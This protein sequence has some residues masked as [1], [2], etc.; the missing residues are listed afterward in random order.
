MAS[1]YTMVPYTNKQD[2]GGRSKMAG[3]KKATAKPAGK[4]AIQ[5][6]PSGK[7][8]KFGGAPAQ[9]PGQTAQLGMTGKGPEF[10]QGGPSGKMQKF[11]PVKPQRPGGSAVTNSGGGGY[12]KNK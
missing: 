4:Q 11:T 8:K 9:T 1:G 5:A 10:I 6:G 3:T 7:M 12:A 2:Y